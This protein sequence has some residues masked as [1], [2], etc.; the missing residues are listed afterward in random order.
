MHG[1]APTRTNFAIIGV[2]QSNFKECYVFHQNL[3]EIDIPFIQFQGMRQIISC[4]IK[5]CLETG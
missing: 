3:P 2:S 1:A 4:G 5:I